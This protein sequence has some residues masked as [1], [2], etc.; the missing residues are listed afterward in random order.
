MKEIG[1][2]FIL[3]K[4]WQNQLFWN[5]LNCSKIFNGEMIKQIKI[6]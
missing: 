2:N 3:P 6:I 1:S 4:I 5:P